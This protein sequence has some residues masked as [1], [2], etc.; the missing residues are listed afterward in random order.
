MIDRI[1]S[2]FRKLFSIHTAEIAPGPLADA[3]EAL[4]ELRGDNTSPSSG[5][6]HR[7]DVMENIANAGRDAGYFNFGNGTNIVGDSAKHYRNSK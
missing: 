5:G 4:D 7:P 6:D 2:A 3:A 1:R